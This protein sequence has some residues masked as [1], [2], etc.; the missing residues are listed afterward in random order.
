MIEIPIWLLV[1]ILV[2]DIPTTGLIIMAIVDFIQWA[3]SIKR[4]RWN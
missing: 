3:N 4:P 1:I 2:L